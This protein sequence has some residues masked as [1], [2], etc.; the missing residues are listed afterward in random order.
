MSHMEGTLGELFVYMMYITH[1]KSNNAQGQAWYRIKSFSEAFKPHFHVS[2]GL[3]YLSS[4]E[5]Q[6]LF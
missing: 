4:E 3:A 1:Q 5:Q 2:V 6:K